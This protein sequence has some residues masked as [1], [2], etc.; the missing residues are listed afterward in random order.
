MSDEFLKDEEKGKSAPRP[1]KRGTPIGL[2]IVLIWAVV[3]TAVAVV[4]ILGQF[5]TT[6]PEGEDG[7]WIPVIGRS[8]PKDTA[9]Q[10]A[11]TMVA[12]MVDADL[13]AALDL[14]KS[15]DY[16]SA[17]EAVKKTIKLVDV[18]AKLGTEKAEEKKAALEG[19]LKLFEQNDAV[20]YGQ[21][22]KDLEALLNPPPAESATA[23]S[24][25]KKDEKPAAKDEK[26]GAG[27]APAESATPEGEKPAEG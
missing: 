21:A 17:R 4:L 10:E 25:A 23:E 11:A 27:E 6:A 22:Q 20:G 12:A 26:P 15:G 16:K 3:A 2:V 19:I 18:S 14:A 1:R 24:G 9:K 8:A 13:Q 7:G 5:A